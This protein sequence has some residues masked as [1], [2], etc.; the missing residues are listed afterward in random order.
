MRKTC[1]V[2]A[3]VVS[4][5]TIG[6]MVYFSKTI[7]LLTFECKADDSL[8]VEALSVKFHQNTPTQFFMAD[9]SNAFY[10]F[11]KESILLQQRST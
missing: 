2:R 5:E 7:S 10:L 11:T 8:N 1:V 9:S 3:S 6:D 4:L